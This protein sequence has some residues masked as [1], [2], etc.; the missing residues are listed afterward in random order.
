LSLFK[1]YEKNVTMIN[2]F[3]PCHLVVRETRTTAE[4]RDKEDA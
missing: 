1:V 2:R 3:Y 4:L